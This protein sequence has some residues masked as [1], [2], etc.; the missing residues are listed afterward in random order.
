MFNQMKEGKYNQF[1]E[2]L[3]EV[4]KSKI[5]DS[6]SLMSSEEL[7]KL[8]K[9]FSLEY[10]IEY[11]ILNCRGI[12]PLSI[13]TSNKIHYS[14]SENFI[15]IS[16]VVIAGYCAFKTNSD[17]Y[18]KLIEF[19]SNQNVRI[20]ILEF[21]RLRN[22]FF[23]HDKTKL[24]EYKK[25]RKQFNSDIYNRYNNVKNIELLPFSIDY[26]EGYT[27]YYSSKKNIYN[28]FTVNEKA[29]IQKYKS[30]V[31]NILE[32]IDSFLRDNK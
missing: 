16:D 21:L 2:L 28:I 9:F 5:I 19:I 10:K 24:N 15:K 13:L 20:C 25:L 32:E 11:F 17:N 14:R 7:R 27:E 3:N 30:I 8:L 31:R 12:T 23:K 18:H 4:R 6:M 22:T 29:K 26:I 1:F